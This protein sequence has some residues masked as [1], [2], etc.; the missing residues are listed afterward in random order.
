LILRFHDPTEGSVRIDDVKVRAYTLESLRRQITLLPQEPF[1]LGATVRENLLYGKPDATDEE[2]I[3]ALRAAA[4]EDYILSS[5]DGLDTSVQQ[6]GQSLSG[7]QR[8]RLAIA[9]AIL[10]D[11]PILLL[12]EPTTGLDARSEKEVLE[13]LDRLRKNRTTITIA[14]R[15]STIRSA[16]RILVL[17][18]GKLIEDGA[19]EKLLAQDS[20]FRLLAN[21]QDAEQRSRGTLGIHPDGSGAAATNDPGIAP[22]GP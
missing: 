3:T 16:E 2:L 13:S 20:L 12:D 11:A 6:R 10:K 22:A 1:I 19:P 9:R 15:F 14:H 17:D 7:G 8:Q 21:I 4:L 18:Q 5:P